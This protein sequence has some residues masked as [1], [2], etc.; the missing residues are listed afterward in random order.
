MSNDKESDTNIDAAPNTDPLNQPQ[1]T[2]T[3]TTN[4]SPTNPTPIFPPKK[5]R[6]NPKG[7]GNP[8]W[9]DGTWKGGPGR[10]KEGITITNILKTV[11]GITGSDFETLLAT[12]M[13]NAKMKYDSG[14]DKRSYTTMLLSMMEK[15]TQS[16]PTQVN[17]DHSGKIEHI[18]A[19]QEQDAAITAR[20]KERALMQP[21]ITVSQPVVIDVDVKAVDVKTVSEAESVAEAK[22]KVGEGGE[23]DTTVVV[24]SAEKVKKS[25]GPVGEGGVDYWVGRVGYGPKVDAGGEQSG[26]EGDGR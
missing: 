14:E 5:R 1:P 17:H 24:Q 20:L 25:T 6:G 11:H 12:H 16:L 18:A 23:V 3:P 2:V 15:V 13:Y 10:P 4:T 8:K 26:S 19:L 22:E 9:S 21:T 7:V